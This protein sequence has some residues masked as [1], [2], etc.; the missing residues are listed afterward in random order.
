VVDYAQ[1]ERGMEVW[2]MHS[3]NRV[4]LSDN[5]VRDPRRRPYWNKQCQVD[6]NPAEEAQFQAVIRSR[7]ALYRIVNNADGFGTIDG[8]PGSF[9]G[10]SLDDLLKLLKTERAM[11]DRY[12][13]HGPQT[14][15]I[16]WLLMGWGQH[17]WDPEG[18]A[19]FIA[20]TIRAFKAGLPEPWQLLVGAPPYF[21]AFAA[22]G[23]IDRSLWMPYGAIESEPCLPNIQMDRDR[24]CT[25]LDMVAPHPTLAGMIGNA[26]TPLLQLP[27][28]L[29]FLGSAW[30]YELRQRPLEEVTRELAQ[31]LY[32]EQQELIAAG[33]MALDFAPLKQRG[34]EGRAGTASQAGALADKLTA[35]LAADGL[36]RPG[37]FARKLFP[38]HRQ[39][40]RDLAAQLRIRAA[41]ENLFQTVKMTTVPEECARLLEVWFDAVLAWEKMHGYQ[42]FI[43][44]TSERIYWPVGLIPTDRRIL[45]FDERFPDFI[46]RLKWALI[47]RGPANVHDA[48]IDAFLAP[49]AERLL[50]KYGHNQVMIGCIRQ[51]KTALTLGIL[52]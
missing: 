34:L 15:M 42:Q 5:G 19:P 24:V 52:Y 16:V 49:I 33:Y 31:Y 32:P 17:G 1:K 4:A 21:A 14:K 47:G 51:M 13:E 22:E 3:G 12:N 27:H 38:D 30:N 11:L 43:D 41:Q 40:A 46:M 20:K 7:E 6:M 29:Y 18:R 44:A 45:P 8:D 50:R 35:L 37:V 48:T 2:I 23:V 25:M 36:G 10:S 28:T 39:A 26:Q 9:L